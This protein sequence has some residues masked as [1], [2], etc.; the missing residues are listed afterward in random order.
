VTINVIQG[1]KGR[2][3]STSSQ[4]STGITTSS[5]SGFIV[6]ALWSGGAFSSLVDSKSNTWN[7]IGSEIS[8]AGASGH[9]R[10][11]YSELDAAKVGAS[12]TVTISQGGT[13]AMSIFVIEVGGGTIPSIFDKQAST[14]DSTSPYA[15]GATASTTQ[16][17]ELI[18]GALGGNSGSNPAT[19]AIDSSSTPTSGWAITSAAEE[20]NGTSFWSGGL[21]SVRVTSTGTYNGAWTESGASSDLAIFTAT[22]KEAAAGGDTLFAQAIF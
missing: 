3:A 1:T 8:F 9:A 19:H 7:L 10:A 18:V 17:I 2:S 20:T 4:A 22:F 6:L 15:S 21:A 13:G 16:A 14:T 5:G 11:Y 12:H